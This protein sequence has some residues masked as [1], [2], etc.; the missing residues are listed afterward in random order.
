VASIYDEWTI[1][2]G[3]GA[4]RRERDVQLSQQEVLCAAR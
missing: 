1:S 4:I 3:Q 2:I